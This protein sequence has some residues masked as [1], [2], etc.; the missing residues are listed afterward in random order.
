MQIESDNDTLI[1]YLGECAHCSITN[2]TGGVVG[3]TQ[4]VYRLWWHLRTKA[5]TTKVPLLISD[6]LAI[7]SSSHR[8]DEN[9]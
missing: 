1:D 8:T 2:C 6:G 4:N 9:N 5:T 7:F 3:Q